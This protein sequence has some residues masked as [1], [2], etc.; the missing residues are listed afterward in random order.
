MD[1]SIREQV[2]NRYK[3]ACNIRILTFFL[4]SLVL[5]PGY[6][7]SRDVLLNVTIRGVYEC[8]VSLHAITEGGTFRPVISSENI[9]DGGSAVL[10]IGEEWLPGEF[11][12]RFDYSAGNGSTPYPCE[13]RLLIGSQDIEMHIN[14]MYC[15][16]AD[17][18]GFQ[19]GEKEN[20]AY[21]AF[22][23]ESYR[24]KEK[25]AILQNFLMSY[26]D[27][28]SG[29]YRKCIREYEKRRRS[30]DRW[31]TER[32]NEDHELFASRLYSLQYVPGTDWGGTERER[33]LSMIDHYFDGADF[34]DPDLTRSS[35]LAGW[36]DSYV[37][38]YGQLAGTVALRD[39][40][41]TLA[42]RRA[43]GQ[44]RTGHPE[45]YG[46]MV[47]YFYRGFEMN[48]MPSGMKALESYLDDPACL[49]SRRREIER[50][51]KGLETLVPGAKAP[52]L[53]LSDD[54]GNTF[55][56]Y[57]SVFPAKYLLLIFWTAGCG[58]CKEMMDA[59]YS[60]CHVPGADVQFSVVAVSLDDTEPDIARWN[61][62]KAEYREWRH[63]RA[64][65]G[66]G[67]RTAA[68]Y[69]IL[70]TPQMVLLD[71]ETKEIV[72]MPGTIA[73]A[74]ALMVPDTLSDKKK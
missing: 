8:S 5:F 17:S 59:V 62:V 30:Y 45:M 31:L 27:I 1:N 41:F 56:L 2:A 19:E 64:E 72:G 58:H 37:N 63:F 44:A 10:V 42:A 13:R 20:S 55:D 26:D 21:I 3:V 69:F 11:V 25:I 34:S 40:L 39:S 49:T 53:L 61:R 51:L 9:H 35:Q 22:S 4:S 6:I 23:G 16:N 74:I 29:L 14:P 47:D 38:L 43:V 66:A 54:E 50:R 70:S 33:I 57:G 48:N 46:W 18:T 67:G 60:Y 12:L 68:D 52:G 65:G 15:N 73:G 28:N 7:F 36:M 32:K 24:Q 71:A